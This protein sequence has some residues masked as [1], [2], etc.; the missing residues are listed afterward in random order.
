MWK[1]IF[2]ELQCKQVQFW[3]AYQFW[4][5]SYGGHFFLHLKKNCIPV[6]DWTSHIHWEQILTI[7]GRCFK[8]FL[9]P[10]L[11][12]YNVVQLLSPTIPLSAGF[13]QRCLSTRELRPAANG[14]VSGFC[15]TWRP[16]ILTLTRKRSWWVKGHRCFQIEMHHISHH[17][18]HWHYC[19]SNFTQLAPPQC[20]N[21]HS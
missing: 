17:N 18:L 21:S 12:L 1:D 11:Y 3:Q 8:T 7:S 4:N 2:N 10:N 19:S 9:G 15:V 13:H 6:V 14:E 16:H 5:P 20:H